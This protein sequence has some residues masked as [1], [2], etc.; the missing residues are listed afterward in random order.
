M[1]G[2]IGSLIAQIKDLGLIDPV[3]EANRNIGSLA[4]C[5]KEGAITNCYA[6]NVDVNGYSS[7]AGLVGDNR[8]AIMNCYSTGNVNGYTNIGG[9]VGNN[10]GLS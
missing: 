7:V 5:L 2:C 4:G 6:Q 1:F 9:L 8:A 10:L 3:L